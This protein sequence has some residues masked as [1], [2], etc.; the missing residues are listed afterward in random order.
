MD[1]DDRPVPGVGFAAQTNAADI[2]TNKQGEVLLQ[3]LKPFTQQALSLD[4]STLPDPSLKPKFL[5]I[6]VTPR[7]GLVEKIDFPLY[8]TGD[9]DGTLSIERDG[10][11]IPGG[12]L[13]VQLVDQKGVVSFS[14]RADQDGYYVIEG[15]D[16]GRYALRLDPM[17][18]AN[19]GI[20]PGLA[21][22]VA[23]GE[24]K[25]S[26]SAQDLALTMLNAPASTGPK[27]DTPVPIWAN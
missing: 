24:S 23:I 7:P 17:Q 2:L 26:L 25:P 11:K 20:N 8:P 21:K 12:G 13:T 9:L 1:G 6:S 10:R 18:A 14:T 16:Y 5:S 22:L 4:Q 3:S 19:L 15:I 27:L